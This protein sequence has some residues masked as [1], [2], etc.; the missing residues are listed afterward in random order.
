MVICLPFLQNNYMRE[1][2]VQLDSSI[3]IDPQ[4]DLLA[5]ELIVV[6]IEFKIKPANVAMVISNT[7]LSFEQAKKQVEMSH[8]NFLRELESYLG[9][10]RL[11]YTIIQTYKD[12]ING[13]ALELPGIAIK[14]L[15]SSKVIKAIYMNHEVSIPNTP[16][17]SRYQI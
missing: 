9:N 5:N 10:Q 17:D 2:R 1:G 16:M 8:T 12:S 3:Y 15:L 7:K 11:S 14:K 13:V 6:I 4:I